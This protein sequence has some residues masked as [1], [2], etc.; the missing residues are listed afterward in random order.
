MLPRYWTISAI[1]CYKIGAQCEKCEIA[2]ELETL[3]KNC[4]MKKTIIELVKKYG[5]P[6]SY[7]K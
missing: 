1:Y 7:L 3:P 5:R 6:E 4:R 2:Q